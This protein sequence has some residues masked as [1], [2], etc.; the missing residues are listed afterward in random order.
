MN[1]LKS[2]CGFGLALLEVAFSACTTDATLLDQVV[3]QPS[4]GPNTDA[5]SNAKN[6]PSA[7]NGDVSKVLPSVGCTAQFP[8]AQSLGQYSMYT[9]H[10]AGE[11]L[12]PKFSVAPHDRS[13]YVWVPNDYQPTTPYRVTFL[14]MGCGDRNAAATATYKMFSKDK[15]SLYVAM[16]MPPAGFP[17]MGKDCFDNTVGNQSIEWEFMG[18]VASQV[19]KN[20]CVDENRVFVAG[21]S[22]GAWVSNMFGC[23]FAG[24][25][26]KRKFGPDVSV[27]GQTSV[28]GG[29]VQPDVQCGAKEAALWIHDTEDV[30]NVLGGNLM[31]SLPRVLE[32]NGC[33]GGVAGE[34]VPW[35][36]VPLFSDVCKQF[37][38]CPTEFPV[39]FCKTSGLGHGSQDARAIPAF[40]EFQNSMNPK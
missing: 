40:I 24:K 10:V 16:N 31:T 29:P 1:A 9:Q 17:P 34:Q 39:V 14:F 33:E 2:L 3:A 23:Y 27:R 6:S 4:F 7:A 37:K 5:V 30:E 12:D 32:V 13:Y 26:P 35:G 19:Q 15:Q 18:N 36:S 21:Y 38:H 28:T 11:T 25:D 20:F 8:A 22:S